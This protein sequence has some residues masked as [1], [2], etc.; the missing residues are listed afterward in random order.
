MPLKINKTKLNSIILEEYELLLKENG[1]DELFGRRNPMKKIEKNLSKFDRLEKKLKGKG[2]KEDEFED[3]VAKE[4]EDE[5]EAALQ[6][7]K[8][9]MGLTEEEKQKLTEDQLLAEGRLEDV[10]KKYVELDKRGLIADLS[11]ED[12]SGNNAYLGWMAKQLNDFYSLTR[13][14]QSK[15]DQMDARASHVDDI[16]RIVKQFHQNKQRLDKK[17]LY[18]YKYFEDLE[19]ELGKLGQTRSQKRK[20]EKETAM[21]GS[22]IIFEDENF[23]A[24]RPFTSAASC[25]YGANSK[26]CISARGNK[27]FD[28]YTSE[29]KGFVFV[30]MNNL[31]DAVAEGDADGKEFALVYDRDGE[32]ET[33]FDIDD[34]ERTDDDYRDYAAI[35]ILEGIFAGTKYEGKGRDIYGDIFKASNQADDDDK[36]PGIYKAIAKS[37]EEQYGDQGL[38]EAPDLEDSDSPLYDLAEWLMQALVQPAWEIQ[39]AGEHSVRETPPGPDPEALQKIVD[40]F[41]GQAEHSNIHYNMDEQLYFDGSMGM[42]LEDFPLSEWSESVQD[43]YDTYNSDTEKKIKEIVSEALDSNNIWPDDLELMWDSR[44]DRSKGKYDVEEGAKILNIRMDFRQ[45]YENSDLSGFEEFADRVLGYDSEYDGAKEEIIKKLIQSFLIKSDAYTSAED[46]KN[47]TLETMKNFDEAEVGDGEITFYGNLQVQVPRIPQF[48]VDLSKE[49][50]STNDPGP[51]YP[52]Q[53][54]ISGPARGYDETLFKFYTNKAKKLLHNQEVQMIWRKAF[55][56]MF[57]KVYDSAERMAKKQT[58]LDLQEQDDPSLYQAADFTFNVVQNQKI[59]HPESGK[60]TI[61]FYI[62]IP[63]RD[64]TIDTSIKFVKDVDRL[65]DTV[66]TAYESTMT[67]VLNKWFEIWIAQIKEKI[68]EYKKEKESVEKGV[69]TVSSVMHEVKIHSNLQNHF[70]KWRQFRDTNK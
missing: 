22:E 44:W 70:N 27:Y 25:H 55:G 20:F 36:V 52:L 2:F 1:L 59:Y 67:N 30:R 14:I 29:G 53:R 43:E 18:Q 45:E 26:W 39:G 41:D 58:K 7:L 32:L 47:N 31:T 54:V 35:N 61:P 17:D 21:E 4:K 10:K 56:E 12:P 11:N 13:G 42:E 6:A 63:L 57:N 19:D 34:V 50:G 38:D 5:T 3:L 62:E 16:K 28:S 33:T 8:A 66:E 60:L 65:W 51:M 24:I 23:F 37:V 40:K 46:L 64:D 69:E 49:V 9:K 48:I 15:T 68:E